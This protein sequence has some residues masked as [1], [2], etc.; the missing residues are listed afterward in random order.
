GVHVCHGERSAGRAVAVFDDAARL[1]AADGGA[2]VHARDRDRDVLRGGAVLGRDRQRVGGRVGGTCRV[3]A[4]VVDGVGPRAIVERERAVRGGK[5]ADGG[6]RVLAAVDVRDRERAAGTAVAVF[7]H[8]AAGV[9]ADRCIV[10][11]A[12]DRDRDVLRGGAVL[13]RNRQRVG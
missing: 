9:A 7:S 13:G 2:V 12:G 1:R 3:H 4:G 8:A 11:H 5:C 6:E 10:V